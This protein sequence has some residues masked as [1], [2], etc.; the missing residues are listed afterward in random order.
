MDTV[1]YALCIDIYFIQT[2]HFTTIL[3]PYIFSENLKYDTKEITQCK[4]P[5]VKFC[6]SVKLNSMD[7]KMHGSYKL[8][9]RPDRPEE[10][11]EIRVKSRKIRA[12][13]NLYS[14]SHWWNWKGYLEIDETKGAGD[15]YFSNPPSDYIVAQ[16]KGVKYDEYMPYC[17]V[18][19]VKDYSD[20]GEI[21]YILCNCAY[22]Y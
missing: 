16:C 11:F 9:P 18:L 10:E 14:F 6:K 2:N 7:L 20:E 8:V 12:G 17:S 1:Q 13:I 5:G 19:Y 4:D 3:V 21:S 15:G 22:V